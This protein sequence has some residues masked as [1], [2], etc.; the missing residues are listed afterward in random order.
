VNGDSD[1]TTLWSN[2]NGIGDRLP[3]RFWALNDFVYDEESSAAEV[4]GG[5]ASLKFIVAALKRRAKFWCTIAAVGFVVGCGL[6]VAFP[7]GYQASTSLWLVPGPYENINTAAN[8]DQAMAQTRTV[9][10]LAVQQL[11]IPE[12]AA[13]F[14]GTYR[15]V[16]VTERV[17][18]ITANARSS[19]Q[20]V[21]NAEAVAAGFLKF[22]AQEMQAQ[23]ALVLASLKQQ[24]NQAQ[25]RLNSINSQIGQLPAQP[26][27]SSQQT[28]LK[29]LLDEKAQ[30]ENNLSQFQQTVFGTRTGNGSATDAAV[31]GSYVLDPAIPLAHSRLKPLVLNAA[32]GAVGGLF[33]GMAIVVISA[34]VSDRLR[35]RDDVAQALG[36]PV[37]LS[38]CS[39]RQRRWLPVRGGSAANEANVQRIAGYLRHAVAGISG[40]TASLMIVPVDDLRV[41][42]LSLVSLAVSCAR[43]GKQVVVADL[44]SGAPA[45]RLLGAADPGVR[46]ASV[47]DTRLTVAVPERDDVAPTG[48]FGGR[49]VPAER[50]SFTEAVADA[51]ASANLLL[52]LAAVEPSLSG[53]HLATWASDAVAMVTAGQS[54]WEKIHSVAELIRLSGMR[55]D[56]AVLVGA[57]KTD[58]SVGLVQTPEKVL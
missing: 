39:V 15:A 40:R 36:A 11:R 34:L 45:A 57:D 37:R 3:E 33:A 24:A 38:V 44:C 54:S 49:P 25:Q 55:L 10:A 17:M 56:S 42:A 43:E 20:A 8:N 5:L 6:Y 51:C 2:G 7:P 26:T 9:A 35:R 52:I 13:S 23:Q 16:P 47:Q 29:K 12:S 48:P 30:A 4:T 28:Q 19:S 22:R 21:L 14:L 58:E 41:P 53:E 31:K 32:V 1:R 27:S 18:V 50:S 46:L